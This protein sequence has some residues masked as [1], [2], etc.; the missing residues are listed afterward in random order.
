MTSKATLIAV[1]ATLVLLIAPRK[2]LAQYE[3]GAVETSKTACVQGYEAGQRLR[4]DGKLLAARKELIVCAQSSCPEVVNVDCIRWLSE[5]EAAIPSVVVS[6]KDTAG[7][8]TLEVR[9]RIDSIVVTERLLGTAIELDPGPHRL[10]FEHGDAPAIEQDIVVSQGEKN[11]RVAVSFAPA[12]AVAPAPPT[13]PQP[14]PPPPDGS[15]FFDRFNTLSYI[16]FGVGAAGL[17]V[18]T[19]T[20]AMSLSA[21]SDT[22]AQCDGDGKC[23]E[24]AREDY[25]STIALA[26]VS[27]V[28]FV[29][30]ILGV[31]VGVYSLFM[32]ED[33]PPAEQ[34][35]VRAVVG[36][37]SLI[38]HGQF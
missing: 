11:R 30:G 27:N 16:G 9:V 7:R 20:G 18:G 36:P 10:R 23:P 28:G 38:L 4:K 37:G 3:G 14:P 31:G 35:S 5:V 2:A 25:D 1:A 21:L 17:L 6:A 19:I 26:N 13:P 32:N 22:E 34:A 15:S 8:D 33:A 29:L 12:P 24:S